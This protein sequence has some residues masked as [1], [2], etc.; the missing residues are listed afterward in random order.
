MLN[1]AVA[2]AVRSRTL[3]THM[4]KRVLAALASFADETGM[5]HHAL[6]DICTL[7]QASKKTVIQTIHQ[8][9]ELRELD[10]HSCP[11][12]RGHYQIKH[13]PERKKIDS[14]R[15]P[16][17]HAIRSYRELPTRVSIIF[18]ALA[19]YAGRQGN[20]IFPSAKTIARDTGYAI[21][22]ARETVRWLL[23]AGILA[24]DT[25]CV[26]HKY[27]SRSGFKIPGWNAEQ[28]SLMLWP[29]Q[30]DEIKLLYQSRHR[31]HYGLDDQEQQEEQTLEA[32]LNDIWPNE[33][34]VS[35]LVPE[36]PGDTEFWSSDQNRTDWVNDD[37]SEEIEEEAKIE[38]DQTPEINQD[39]VTEAEKN[40]GEQIEQEQNG[41][42]VR[43]VPGDEPRKLRPP[44]DYD[45]MLQ[46]INPMYRD[47]E[48]ADMIR[49][50]LRE[51]IRPRREIT[52]TLKQYQQAL[53]QVA[54]HQT[55]LAQSTDTSEHR[56]SEALLK[57]YQ[58]TVDRYEQQTL[59]R[60]E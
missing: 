54:Y 13:L 42:I 43:F 41:Q 37:N 38:E 17:M 39:I 57:Y 45:A 28:E 15:T 23:R 58:L 18:Q 47:R 31:K 6:P 36:E 11:G 48:R 20:N 1:H 52:V 35:Q 14:F 26:N 55:V 9:A 8:L 16:I 33:E 34:Q 24:Q 25:D 44:R 29:E 22:T 12:Q 10:I 7:A 27:Q 2:T 30:L 19:A 56:K 3:E 60:L 32:T 51:S 50:Q 21:K 5:V 40:Q 59:T 49:V 53:D 46:H 4:Q